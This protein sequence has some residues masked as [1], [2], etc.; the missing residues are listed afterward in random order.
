MGQD[1]KILTVSAG[2]TYDYQGT[3]AQFE[4]GGIPA[5]CQEIEW[6]QDAP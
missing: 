2:A 3:Y 5:S 1:E 6:Q 4:L